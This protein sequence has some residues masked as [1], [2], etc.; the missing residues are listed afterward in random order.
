MRRQRIAS[1]G[2][3]T[4]GSIGSGKQAMGA[5]DDTPP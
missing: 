2:Q 4:T 1:L 3:F 5:D